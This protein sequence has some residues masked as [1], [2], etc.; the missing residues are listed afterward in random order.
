MN[1]EWVEQKILK[2][3]AESDKIVH[4]FFDRIRS[5]DLLEDGEKAQS[6]RR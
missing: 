2:L 5:M 1:K 4:D 6:S 3:Q